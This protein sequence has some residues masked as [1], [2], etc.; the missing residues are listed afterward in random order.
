MSTHDAAAGAGAAV[1]D[2]ARLG[3]YM[4]R[5]VADFE[6]EPRIRQVEG[7][8]SNPTFIVDAGTRRFVLRRKPPGVLLQSAH[9]VDREYRVLKALQGSAVPVPRVRTLCEDA[10]VLGSPFYLMDFVD[11]RILTDQTLPGMTPPQRRA[12]YD[13]LNRVMAALHA[14]DHRAVGLAGFGREERYVERQIERWTRQYRDAQTRRIEAMEALSTWLPA[15]VPPQRDAGLVHGDFRLDNV[16]FHA[17][18][19]RIVAVLDWELSTLGDPLADFAYH[20]LSWRIGLGVHHTLVGMDDAELT[21]LGIPTEAEHVAAYCERS[22]RGTG[23]RIDH[24]AFYLVLNLFRLAAIQ[25]G[26]ARRAL[27]GNAANSRAQAVAARV[28]ATAEAGWA[29]ARGH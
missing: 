5:H 11:G 3:G 26:I 29:I 7:G 18:E 19:P 6:G 14:V 1:P 15:Q 13:E 9:A 2:A 20:C 23:G 21:A 27:D 28:E 12:H 25:Q 24:W 16:V 22:G 4:R 8:Q 17:T 10:D